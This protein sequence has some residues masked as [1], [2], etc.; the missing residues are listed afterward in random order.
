MRTQCAQYL[1]ASLVLQRLGGA[2]VSAVLMKATVVL[3]TVVVHDAGVVHS[4]DLWRR[5][6]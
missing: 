6:E 2:V 5:V 3:V 4:L 1:E